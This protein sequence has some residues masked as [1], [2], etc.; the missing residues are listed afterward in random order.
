MTGRRAIRGLLAACAISFG[1]APTLAVAQ[2]A[3]QALA[4]KAFA[5]KK[6]PWGDP[7]FRG[8]WPLD[9]VAL[10]PLQR[11]PSRGEREF[12]TD[13]EFE[14]QQKAIGRRTDAAAAAVKDRKLN[15]LVFAE[16]TGAGRRTSLLV[17]PPNGR[18]PEL[19]GEGKR[20]NAIGRSVWVK[21]Q[22]FDWVTDFDS[23]DRC[24][25]RGFPASMLPFTHNS[26]VRIFQSP[27][28]V[29]IDLEMIHDA[30][31]IPIGAGD[32][33]PAAVTGWMGD[34]RGRWEGQTLVIETANIRPGAAPINYST[35][36][37]PPNNTIPMSRQAK[38]VERL[39]MTG[40]DSIL[41]EM[42]FS[43]PVIWTAP[44]TVRFDW[45]RDE[46]YQMFEYACHE[47]NTTIRD[48]ILGSR[49]LRAKDQAAAGK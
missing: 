47:G 1:F 35:S 23:W 16:Q 29:V 6:T 34:S 48:D 33:W 46:A 17:D 45:R 43:D 12:L 28:Y 40:P 31:I 42:T 11:P 21:D 7:D 39:T 5:P 32:R 25:T 4:A 18:L 24:I 14:S 3:P 41:Y 49:A 19:T 27:G 9:D 44:F 22:T 36:G 38:A 37:A 10:L 13:A 30:R 2:G 15:I 26:G 8:A 20:L